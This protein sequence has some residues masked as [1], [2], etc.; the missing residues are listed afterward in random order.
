M[1]NVKKIDVLV[2]DLEGNLLD[3]IY[4]TSA[5]QLAEKFNI[6]YTGVVNH[7]NNNL[8]SAGKKYQ[9]RKIFKTNIPERIGNISKIVNSGCNK[10]IHKYYKD[11]YI[12]SYES[13]TDAASNNNIDI[14]GI[15]KVLTEENKTVG[16][17]VFKYF[18]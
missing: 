3:V 14:A 11:K 16:G 2:Y 8:V 18:Y 10:K 17:F 15:S 1:S 13:L 5:K 9:F 12:C 6:D 7:L 4:Q